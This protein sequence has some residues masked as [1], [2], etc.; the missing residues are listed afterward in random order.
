MITPYDSV[1][2][3][4]MQR[5][6][7][8]PHILGA[9]CAQACTSQ[10]YGI[11]VVHRRIYMAQACTRPTLHAPHPTSADRVK[12][13]RTDRQTDRQTDMD[14][15]TP[16]SSRSASLGRRQQVSLTRGGRQVPPASW[17]RNASLSAGLSSSLGSI[18]YAPVPET[19]RTCG[20]DG[21][22]KY[23]QGPEGVL[24]AGL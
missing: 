11:Y 3:R 2:A 16:C 10:P 21:R 9:T 22:K 12:E 1:S 6:P 20:I 7:A 17:I 8:A 24:C 19:E 5:R 18:P 23:G 14:R 4:Y 13:G 15:S